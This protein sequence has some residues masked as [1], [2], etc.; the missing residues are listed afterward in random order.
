MSAVLPNR[1]VLAAAIAAA[2]LPVAG[3]AEPTNEEL[4]QKIEELS[5]KVLV[6]ERKLEVQ[7]ETAKTAVASTPVVKASPKGF[8]IA[9]ADSKNQVKLRG[10]VHV[11]GR[12]FADD[13]PEGLKDT[14]QATRVRPIIEGTL[15]GIYDFRFTP[16][17]GQGRTVIQDAY[18][19]A[20]FRPEAQVTVGKFKSP[21]GLERIQSASDIRMVARGYPTQ[22]APNR[23]LGVQLGGAFGGDHLS[24]QLAYLNG[25]NDG[26]SSETFTDV[27][28]NDDKEWAARLF[29][30]PFS[31]SDNFALRGL[32]LGIAGTYTSQTGTTAQPLLA[33]ARTPSQST[34]FRYRTGATATI[35]DGERTRIA[36]Q[37]Y[38]YVGPFGLMGEYTKV[39]QDV[40]RTTSA[41][42]REDTLDTTAWQAQAS[43]FLTGEEESF[44]GFKPNNVFSLD[45]NTWGAFE[46]VARYQEFDP[47]DDAFVGGAASFADPAGPRQRCGDAAARRCARGTGTA[48]PRSRSGA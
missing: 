15:G 16:D 14:W 39:T 37:F 3:Q 28:V 17:F 22:L 48:A 38:Y 36:P 1:R 46:L 25:S 13:D 26:G 12:F 47:D 31:D 7:D 41:G 6:L 20:R 23:D 2:L 24:Y 29:A 11:D 21:V 9:S 40:S 10:V 18:V 19:T 45:D 8:S 30:H 32:G 43:W 33:V 34:F 5:Q 27:D 4:L 35:A 42:R 44:K